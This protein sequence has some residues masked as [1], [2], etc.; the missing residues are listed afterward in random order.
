MNY[1]VSEFSD[2]VSVAVNIVN[3]L[4][5]SCTNGL[6]I[7]DSLV[8]KTFSKFPK[9]AVLVQFML[10]VNKILLSIITNL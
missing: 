3:I 10:P 9:N 6:T 8:T 7:A 2:L 5:N 1:C 4:S